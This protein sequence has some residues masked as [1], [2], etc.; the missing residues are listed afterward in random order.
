MKKL[1]LAGLFATAMLIMGCAAQDSTTA[2]PAPADTT[3]PGMEEPTTPAP[4]TDA[5]A[6]PTSDAPPP[7]T[8]AAPAADAPAPADAAPKADAAPADAPKG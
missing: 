2:P 3:M 7:A 4:A 5:P 1:T 8:D 6:T